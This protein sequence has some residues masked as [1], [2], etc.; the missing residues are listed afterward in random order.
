VALVKP[1]VFQIV[2][3][4]NSGK[5]TVCLKLIAHLSQLGLKIAT[6]KHHGHGGKPDVCE[7]KDSG[8]HIHAGAAISLVEGAGRMLIQAENDHWSLDEEVEILT[9]FKPDVILI[10]GYKNEHYPK[11][12]ILRHEHD[13]ELIGRLPNIKVILHRNE[14]LE[15]HLSGSALPSFHSND[16]K[17]YQWISNYI[18]SIKGNF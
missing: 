5:T 13:L 8:R 3:Y 4:Q 14:D 15:K 16:E 9:F 7:T 11:A 6:I 17:A 2:G 12:V 10:E 1:A 18:D